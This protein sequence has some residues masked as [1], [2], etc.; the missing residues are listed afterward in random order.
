VKLAKVQAHPDAVRL[1]LGRAH[2]LEDLTPDTAINL[3]R[4]LIEA[5][6]EAKQL[7]GADRPHQAVMAHATGRAPR[8][9]PEQGRERRIPL[10]TGRVP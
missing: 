1:D 10:A 8:L 9:R 5:G 2:A 6:Q 3:G 7:Q 4:Q